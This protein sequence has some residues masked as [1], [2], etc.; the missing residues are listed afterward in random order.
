MGMRILDFQ[1]IKGDNTTIL[2]FIQLISFIKELET[3][4]DGSKLIFEHS[5]GASAT[6]LASLVGWP[7]GAGNVVSQEDVVSRP[8]PGCG[9]HNPRR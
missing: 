5:G 8:S 3:L 2:V 6:P 9:S 4:P 7:G 1:W